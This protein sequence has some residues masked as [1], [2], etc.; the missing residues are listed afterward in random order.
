MIFSTCVPDR[1]LLPFAIVLP[2]AAYGSVLGYWIEFHVTGIVRDWISI[3]SDMRDEV[4]DTLKQEWSTA[5]SH[6]GWASWSEAMRRTVGF[7]LTLGTVIT[8]IALASACLTQIAAQG[9]V[10]LMATELACVMWTEWR[11]TEHH[12][13]AGRLMALSFLAATLITFSTLID[14]YDTAT[15][16]SLYT[17]NCCLALLFIMHPVSTSTAKRYFINNHKLLRIAALTTRRILIF[18]ELANV[19]V[20]SVQLYLVRGP[21]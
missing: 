16:V 2:I 12:V 15:W 9:I 5:V 18:A 1:P 20:F 11:N 17:L 21:Q 8:F 13:P 3:H 4:E 14:Q 19:T 7:V 10:V 6:D